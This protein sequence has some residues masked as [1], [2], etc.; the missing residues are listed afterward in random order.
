MQPDPLDPNFAEATSLHPAV[1]PVL[2]CV[3]PNT[4]TAEAIALMSEAQTS[5]VL[6]TQQQRPIGIFTERDL[7]RLIASSQFAPSQP[8]STV[9]S[10]SVKTLCT[11]DIQDTLRIFQQMQ[12]HQLRH[13]PVVNESQ[14]L[15]GIVTKE[16]LRQTLTF[17]TLLKLKQ[18]EEVMQTEVICASADTMVR[19]IAKKNERASGELCGDFRRRRSPCWHHYRTRYC[20]V[21]NPGVGSGSNPPPKP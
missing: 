15:V 7:V 5:Y 4:P 3:P 18:V 12:Q 6:I 9:M 11:A 16:S 21:S 20:A 17:S 2:V 8:I 14:Q 1:V 10:A 13:L 19:Q